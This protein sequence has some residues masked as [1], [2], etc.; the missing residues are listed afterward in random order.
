MRA[1]SGPSVTGDDD[2]AGTASEVLDALAAPVAEREDDSAWTVVTFANQRGVEAA[3]EGLRL[4]PSDVA[5]CPPLPEV[6]FVADALPVRLHER[7]AV[8]P[9]VR[10][11]SGASSLGE[12]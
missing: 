12:P 9:A 7:V 4:S 8:R 5:A 3:L 10:R 11:F 2:V 1:E 6:G